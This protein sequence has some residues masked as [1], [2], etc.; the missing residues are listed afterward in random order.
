MK[1]KSKKIEIIARRGLAKFMKYIQPN[2]EQLTQLPNIERP[3]KVLLLRPARIGDLLVSTP[4]IREI[5]NRFP[6]YTLDLLLGEKNAQLLSADSNIR[7]IFVYRKS[8]FQILQIVK[9]LRKEKYDL[10]LDLSH[11]RSTT[12]AILIPFLNIPYRISLSKKTDYVSNIIIPQTITPQHDHMIVVLGQ[13]LQA[14][15]CSLDSIHLKPYYPIAEDRRKWAKKSL[16]NSFSDLSSVVAIN[17]SGSSETRFWGIKNF[18]NLVKSLIEQY[19][20]IGCLLLY[21][22]TDK[23]RAQKIFEGV[24]SARCLLS[25]ATNHIDDFAAFIQAS[26]VLISA[27]TSAIHF[28][29]ALAVP[30]IGL[31]RQKNRQ[32]HPYSV[33]HRLVETSETLLSVITVDDVLVAFKELVQEIQI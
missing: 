25:A 32:W 28:A 26:N 9:R 30:V 7:R 22:P 23:N 13:L 1:N 2:S 17:I 8:G 24:N 14:F 11:D 18:Q 31:F 29:S 20:E 12:L 21:A 6:Q 4:V 16:N 33:P 27:D 19:P 15:G 3:Y 5:K 10:L